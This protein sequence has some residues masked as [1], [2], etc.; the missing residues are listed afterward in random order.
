MT[1]LN[2]LCEAN[3]HKRIKI[4]QYGET[5]FLTVKPCIPAG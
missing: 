2:C 5:L 1:F 4:L 3:L